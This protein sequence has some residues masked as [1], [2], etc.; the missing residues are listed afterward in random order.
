MMDDTDKIVE[1]A[2]TDG[3]KK[4]P[5]EMADDDSETPSG[6]AALKGMFRAMKSGDYAAAFDAL[7]AAVEACQDDDGG[8]Y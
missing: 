6:P 2:M 7:K 3:K 4:E 8:D 5:D 1:M